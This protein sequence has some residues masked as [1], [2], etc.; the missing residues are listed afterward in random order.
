LIG[1]RAKSIY[2]AGT[3]SGASIK[4]KLL[5]EQEF[6]MRLYR[7]KRHKTFFRIA[8]FYR[9]NK[10]VFAGRVGTDDSGPPL[11]MGS[12]QVSV[13]WIER[14]RERRAAT[15]ASPGHRRRRIDDSLAVM[16][17]TL[18]IAQV[19][20]KLIPECGKPL[21]PTQKTAAS[22][23]HCSKSGCRCSYPLRSFKIAPVEP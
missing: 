22:S 11:A 14:D 12:H 10:V 5:R 4:V 2:E 16:I 20:K 21:L 8:G 23:R 9:R 17:F 15:F 18:R 6:V 19:H 7:T 3:R 13:F 1:K